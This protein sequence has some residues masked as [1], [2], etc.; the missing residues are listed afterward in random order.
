MPSR[1]KRASTPRQPKPGARPRKT[2]DSGDGDAAARDSAPQPTRRVG[3]VAVGMSAGGFEPCRE[4]LGALPAKPGFALVIVQ[5]LAPNH[6]SAL[7][8]LLDTRSPV[9][10]V[11]AGDG[12]RIEADKAYVIPPN[13]LIELEDGTVRVL[14]RVPEHRPPINFFLASLAFTMGD[15]SIA[16]LLSGMGS[17]GVE[18]IRAIKAQGGTVLVQDPKTAR[19]DAMPQAA[20]STG[21]AD[22]VLPPVG[23][24]QKMVEV[25]RH[26]YSAP[27]SEPVSDELHIGD[28]QAEQLV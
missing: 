6:P 28:Q 8:S 27:V 21:L 11:E 5:H 4:L 25:S 14:Q 15:R 19:F 7:P 18:G 12:M 1:K 2:A 23:L 24:A 3:I 9:R 26:A 17:D 10:V 16:V 13:A 22:A 20:I